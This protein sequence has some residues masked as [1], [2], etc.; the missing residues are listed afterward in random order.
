M[1]LAAQLVQAE[2]GNQ[3][4]E[5]KRR[6]VDV[7]LNRKDSPDFPDTIRDVIY[8]EGQFSVV[9]NGAFDKAAWNITDED[10]EAVY[11]EFMGGSRLDSGILYFNTKKTNGTGHYKCGDHW[12]SY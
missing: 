5:G 12:F 8:Q 2:A 7:L 6:A 9:Q 4:L 3:D 11:L 1:E 10:R